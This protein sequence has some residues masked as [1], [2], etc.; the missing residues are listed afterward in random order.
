MSTPSPFLDPL[1]SSGAGD[2]AEP[3][4]P[5][6]A[7]NP[8]DDPSAVPDAAVV[9]ANVAEPT[10]SMFRRG[11][12]VFL[13]NRAAVVGIVIIV[14][15]TLFCFVG[16]LIYHTDQIHTNLAQEELAPGAGH[17]L[18][19]DQ[20]GYDQLGRLMVGGQSSIEVGIAAALL[21]TV[22]G[23]LWGAISG[24]VGGV[25]DALMMRFVDAVMSIPALFLLLFLAS[26]VTPTVPVL[27][28]VVAGVSWLTT[29]RLVR[30]EALTLRVREYV[31]AVRVMGGGGARAVLRHIA[32]NAVGTI[33]VNAT[34]QVADAVLL[35][36][37]MSFLGLG[38]PPPAADWGGM[39]SHGIDFLSQGDWWLIYPPGV[40]IILIVVAFNFIGDALRDAFEVRLQRR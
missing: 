3:A 20:N 7:L 30:G 27:I 26:I 25:V 11:L 9:G 39:L 8:V 22:V 14:A 37:V 36:A 38:V 15:F 12:E 13:E 21:A 4:A 16:P 29:S 17:P 31:Q 28:V 23:T 1:A 32:P 35:I 40:A 18:G 10:R 33:A 19:T 6:R 24:Y 34:F 5:A 2:P